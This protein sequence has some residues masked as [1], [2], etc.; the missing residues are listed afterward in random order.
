MWDV[1]RGFSVYAVTEN[2][3]STITILSPD[4]NTFVSTNLMRVKVRSLDKGNVLY[5]IETDQ[6][7]IEALAYSQDGSILIS[8]GTD[9]NAKV[10]GVNSAFPLGTL[11]G[12]N[13]GIVRILFSPDKTKVITASRDGTVRF[14]KIAP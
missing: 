3:F 2:T 12:H 11:E 6:N 14:W 9:G 8:G 13:G 7:G 5:E 10:W 1:A 4:K